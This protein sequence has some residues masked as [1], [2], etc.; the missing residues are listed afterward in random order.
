MV[1]VHD[2]LDLDLDSP[3]HRLLYIFWRNNFF[4]VPRCLIDSGWIL[5]GPEILYF[6]SLL[7]TISVILSHLVDSWFW[8]FF[9]FFDFFN[10]SLVYVFHPIRINSLFQFF[11]LMLVFWLDLLILY[12]VRLLKYFCICVTW[13]HLLS[14]AW[15]EFVKGFLFCFLQLYFIICIPSSPFLYILYFPRYLLSQ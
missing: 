9:L 7:I 13:C 15:N 11:D 4:F 3:D 6:F 5:S 10:F 8:D 1:F 12:C 14:K 2:L